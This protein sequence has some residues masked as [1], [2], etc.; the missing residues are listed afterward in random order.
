[1]KISKIRLLTKKDLYEDIK[2]LNEDILDQQEEFDNKIVELNKTIANVRKEDEKFT[3]ELENIY[4][5]LKQ[6]EELTKNDTI[7]TLCIL[8][9]NE[10]KNMS[11]VYIGDDK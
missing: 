2:R 6:I 3:D 10:I 1:M 4:Y 7:R 9:R 8:K 11:G 5:L